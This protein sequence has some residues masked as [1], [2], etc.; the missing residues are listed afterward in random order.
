MGKDRALRQSLFAPDRRKIEQIVTAI[1]RDHNGI[2]A[3]EEVKTLFSKLFEIP[4]AAIPDDHEEV[5]LPLAYEVRGFPV[6]VISRHK[7]S[8]SQ[9][10]RRNSYSINPN[11]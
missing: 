2:I 5:S 4:V 11:F 1:D 8:L 10:H 7:P 6:A 9:P 3:V